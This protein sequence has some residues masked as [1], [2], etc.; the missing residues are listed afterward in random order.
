MLI[1]PNFYNTADQNIYNKGY[2]FVPQE[3]F[4][5]GAFSFPTTTEDSP[6]GITTLPTAM[7]MSGG[8]GGGGY[9]GNVNDLMKNYTLDTRKQYFG[10]QPTPLVDDLYQSKLDKSFMGFPSYR[11]QELTGPDMGEYIGSGTDI[12]LEQTTAGK[13]QDTLGNVKDKA[14][15]ILSNVKNFGPISFAL[16]SMDKFN[17]L[18]PADQEFI[19]QNMGYR[20][21]TI[22]GANNSGLNKDI[23]GINTRSLFGNYA[24]YVGEKATSL[25]EMLS[26]K[27]ADKYSEKTGS[28]VSF[29][30][31]TGM[32]ESDDEDAA[33]LANKMNKNNINM[34]NVYTQKEKERVANEKAMAKKAALESR[35]ESARQYD[36]NI[37][38]AT[39]YG[40]GSD[41]K[42]SYDSGQGFGTN[43]TTGGPVSN[44][45]GRGRTDY[46]DGGLA[47]LVDIYD[48]L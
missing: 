1:A 30:K 27:M 28:K 9:T 20:G 13:I 5:G 14:S 19:K 37:H 26:G 7:N 3:R 11:Q 25:G 46:M 44:R 4:R 33:D 6:T 2:S 39:N 23:F 36:S 47:N 15:G 40:L 43:A 16:N 35:L 48:W 38:G 42:Q 21:P 31:E 29:N 45:T 32:F 24:D 8:G 10:S 34:F 12:P 18:S 41:G 17:T 22:F